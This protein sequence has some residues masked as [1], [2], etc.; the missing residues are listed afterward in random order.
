GPQRWS[1]K[2]RLARCAFLGAPF[3]DEHVLRLAL[4]EGAAPP[5]GDEREAALALALWLNDPGAD[6]DTL[7]LQAPLLASV[8]LEVCAAIGVPPAA[9]DGRDAVEVE[10]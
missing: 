7:P 1:E 5:E 9:L 3:L 10:A 8:T 6:A 2:L 4:P